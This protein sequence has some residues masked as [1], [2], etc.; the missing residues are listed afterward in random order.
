MAIQRSCLAAP[1]ALLLC[2][3]A[4]LPSSVRAEPPS[5]ART[6]EGC[7]VARVQIAGEHDVDRV[8]AAADDVWSCHVHDGQID[9]M[10]AADRLAALDALGLPYTLVIRDVQAL[11]DAERGAAPEDYFDDYHSA[12]EILSYLSALATAYPTLAQLEPIGQSLEGRTMYALRIAGPNQGAMSPAVFFFTTVHAREWITSTVTP[13]FA[14][15][16]LSLYGQD[17]YITELLDHVEFILVPLGN[18]DG[19]EI[20]WGPDRLWRKN[21]R[22]NANGTIGVDIN[23][24]WAWGWGSDNGSSGTPSSNTYRGTA[25]FSEPETQVLRDVL[26]ANP[27]IRA[28]NDIHS[29]SQLIMWPWGYTNQLTPDD[30]AFRALGQVMEQTIESVLGTPYTI[31]PVYTAIYPVSG[32]SIDWAYGARGVWA[33]TYELRDLGASG[34]ILPASQIRPQ[35]QELTP[36]LLALANSGLVRFTQITVPGGP[37]TLINAGQDAAFD[38]TI[39]S[40]VEALDPHSATLHYRYD[41]AGPFA[42]APLVHSGG[43][44]FVATLPATNCTSAPQFYLSVD[45]SAGTTTLPASAPSTVFAATVQSGGVFYSEPLDVNP[46]WQV[47]GQW[48]YGKPTGGGGSH[49]FKDPNSGFTNLYV[50]GYNLQGDYT[51]AMPEYH[52]TST[53]IDCAGRFGVKLA[54]RRWL[55]VERAPFDRARVRVSSDGSNWTTV[56]ENPTVETADNAWTLQTFDIAAVADDQ[57]TVYLRWSIGPTDNGWTYCGWNIDDVTL[58]AT[59]CVPMPGDYDGDGVLTALDAAALGGCL[60]GPDA[61]R[62]PGC[63]I[64]RFDADDDVDLADAA[65]FQTQLGT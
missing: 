47:Q 50:Y 23:R 54:F 1:L 14:N 48:G 17:A 60:S 39:T 55:G 34:F 8:V 12:D 15:H 33:F 45:G 42:A 13:Y 63:G 26:L 57:P 52:L 31:G 19:F 37:P 58:E 51:N 36:A 64:F 6:Y 22:P 21:R 9:V 27:H 16:V 41:P 65:Q 46:G 43:A 3:F 30:A 4:E 40:G 38:V 28:M 49:G 61:P 5:N 32:A 20:T 10:F 44:G 25:P 59:G 56:W 53:A 35:N 2:F 62:A 18:P 7:V 29:Y 11:I 24:N